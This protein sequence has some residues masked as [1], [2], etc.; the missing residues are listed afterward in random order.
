MA[1]PV[2]FSAIGIAGNMVAPASVS[3]SQWQGGARGGK[4]FILHLL[5]KST[6]YSSDMMLQTAPKEQD[7]RDACSYLV[8]QYRFLER[9]GM[10]VQ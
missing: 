8:P 4:G 2:I 5:D 7:R 10:Q 9:K 3:G 1:A 6:K